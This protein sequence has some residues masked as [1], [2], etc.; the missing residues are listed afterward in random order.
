MNQIM[1]PLINIY[2]SASNYIQQTGESQ[3]AYMR[4]GLVIQVFSTAVIVYSVASAIFALASAGITA[5]LVKSLIVTFVAVDSFHLGAGLCKAATSVWESRVSSV[6]THAF[7]PVSVPSWLWDLDIATRNTY[8][9]RLGYD[10][11]FFISVRQDLANQ[12]SLA[13]QW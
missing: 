1:N 12:E 3:A 8:L 10:L 2:N 4:A 9:F 13:S 5:A 7:I 6:L 11:A